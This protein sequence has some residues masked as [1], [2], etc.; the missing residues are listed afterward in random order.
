MS[1][2]TKDSTHTALNCG[3]LTTESSEE[4][5]QQCA[6]FFLHSPKTAATATATNK[7]AL[8]YTEHSFKTTNTPSQHCTDH[9]YNTHS[10]SPIPSYANSSDNSPSPVRNKADDA[11][12]LLV[13]EANDFVNDA[14][15]RDSQLTEFKLRFDASFAS[16]N[17]DLVTDSLQCPRNSAVYMTQYSNP[18]VDADSLEA[19]QFI[20]QDSLCDGPS[21]TKK[22]S[23]NLYL[24]LSKVCVSADSSRSFG[25]LVDSSRAGGESSLSGRI[26]DCIHP[27]LTP[28]VTPCNEQLG[29]FYL[30]HPSDGSQA[31][32]LNRFSSV[33]ECTAIARG[34]I[35]SGINPPLTPQASTIESPLSLQTSL[36]ESP[37]TPQAFTVDSALSLQES[38]LESPSI[39]SP[40]LPPRVY[41]GINP[42]LSPQG[43][44]VDSMSGSYV[45][46]GS[47]NSDQS[48]DKFH[49]TDSQ[50]SIQMNKRVHSGINPPLSNQVSVDLASSLYMPLGSVSSGI[51]PPLSLQASTVD[52][53][54][55]DY[56]NI[57]A[58]ADPAGGGITPTLSSIV[59]GPDCTVE[60][61][62]T[63]VT[64]CHQNN[65]MYRSY[66]TVNIS[67]DETTDDP[68]DGQ[69]G[70]TEDNIDTNATDEENRSNVL[71]DGKDK[72]DSKHDKRS[73][74]K[75]LK[76][77]GRSNVSTTA[78]RSERNGKYS[79][80][81][82]INNKYSSG[83]SS[84]SN[85]SSEEDSA[86]TVNSSYGSIHNKSSK[87]QFASQLSRSIREKLKRKSSSK[88]KENRKS[89][90]SN[91]SH[92]AS[93]MPEAAMKSRSLPN[94]KNVVKCKGC[95]LEEKN[96]SPRRSAD[97]SARI[98]SSKFVRTL[99][100][101]LKIASQRRQSWSRVI[102]RSQPT[103]PEMSRK[104]RVMQ[105]YTRPRTSTNIF[106][107]SSITA[108][109]HRIRDPL[110]LGGSS[111]QHASSVR[112]LFSPKEKSNSSGGIKHISKP[113]MVSDPLHLQRLTASTKSLM[114][115]RER[116][117][118]RPLVKSYGETGAG[119][120]TKPPIASRPA[121]HHSSENLHQHRIQ[122][123]QN[124]HQELMFAS[125]P[126][127][128][129][130]FHHQSGGSSRGG[131]S[132]Y[133]CSEVPLLL[134]VCDKCRQ[135]VEDGLQHPS[136]WTIDQYLPHGY[137]RTHE[138]RH[139]AEAAKKKTLSRDDC[140]L[141]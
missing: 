93:L 50:T 92:S 132:E 111:P 102:S 39:V 106:S 60:G 136:I 122:P 28:Q 125:L 90:G 68:D 31:S 14:M 79:A 8:H 105:S 58:M 9:S 123:P 128:P 107:S 96:K 80:P 13:Q 83:F 86:S 129:P 12:K 17:D 108:T 59:A 63:S 97:S 115:S 57:E 2:L 26:K 118:V 138:E 51:H 103:T 135:N 23:T 35:S 94:H 65:P 34:S 134:E 95:A 40:Q 124:L 82:K 84:N 41:S 37:L 120:D 47:I 18:T 10:L 91:I 29:S 67:S 53:F 104:H 121:P 16:T 109:Q 139:R 88:L 30:H 140:K 62:E 38:S 110:S 119:L 45:A 126:Y 25:V 44:T 15:L 77:F 130:P 117:Y 36:I 1:S 5:Q 133:S 56:V 81:K 113:I 42:P 127:D 71:T 3:E 114:S 137:T 66:D 7:Q 55:S 52:Y 98:K 75:R 21:T 74:R 131:S 112:S 87:S 48:P 101:P 78:N 46:F 85:L 19:V 76:V 33:E 24:P 54:S 70:D 27:A 73:M 49:M 141:Q 69:V 4:S 99:T 100:M 20:S 32:S 116:S 61:L 64:L 72:K 43:S 6:A 89:E 22:D 11:C